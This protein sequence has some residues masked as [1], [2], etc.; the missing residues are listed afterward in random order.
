M[1]ARE[2]TVNESLRASLWSFCDAPQEYRDLSGHGGDEDY[3][4]FVPDGFIGY[5]DNIVR[6]IGVCDTSEHPVAGGTI[7][8]G[9]HS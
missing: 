7:Y 1:A 5:I 6:A 3:V 8:I 2:T 9:A 4:L